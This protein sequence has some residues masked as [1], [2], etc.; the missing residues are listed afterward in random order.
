MKM[1]T[2]KI[3]DKTK[4]PRGEWIEEPDKAQWEHAG[5]PCLIVRNR[6]G[7]LCGYVGVPEGHPCF[8]KDYE[9]IHVH[10]HGGLTFADYCH[11][12]KEEPRICHIPEPGQPEHVYWLGFDC[13]HFM[14]LI[15]CIHF[16][17]A[18]S[19]RF[20]REDGGNYRNIHYVR[21]QVNDLAEQLVNYGKE[22]KGE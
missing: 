17:P 16:D 7:N 9:S 1:K 21:W 20:W 3:Y 4:W 18:I 14:D 13:G 2:W 6:M 12:G 15:P 5:F 8:G 19:T 22:E 11:E 10:V